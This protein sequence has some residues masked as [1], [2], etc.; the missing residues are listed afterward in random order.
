M[1]TEVLLLCTV[2][3]AL[4]GLLLHHVFRYSYRRFPICDACKMR[5]R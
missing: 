2:G 4:A 3:A 1:R 5:H